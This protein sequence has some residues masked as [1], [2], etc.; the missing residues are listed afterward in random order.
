[1][2]T[3]LDPVFSFLGEWCVGRHTRV[4]EGA[5]LN[6]GIRRFESFL[7]HWTTGGRG[8]AVFGDLQE[9]SSGSPRLKIGKT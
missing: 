5:Q 6:S 8:V 1:M 2:A 3:V 7:P 4:I 9:S